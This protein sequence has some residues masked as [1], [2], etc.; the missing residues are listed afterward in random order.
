MAT[1]SAPAPAAQPPTP[2][3]APSLF[4][5]LVLNPVVLKELRGRMRGARAFIV[6]TVYLVLMSGF[7]LLLYNLYSAA[8]TTPYNA[9]SRGLVGKVVFFGVVGIELLLVSFIAPAFTVGALSGERERQTFDLLR[10]TLLSARS[11]V[12][13]KLGSSLSFVMLLLFAAVPLQ[14]MAFLLGG[15]AIEEVLVANLLL[16]VTAWMFCSAG[17]FFS[18]LMRRTLGATV[19]TYAFVLL[20]VLAL[21][22]LMVPV[23]LFGSFLSFGSGLTV[24]TQAFLLYAFWVLVMTNPLATVIAS[25]VVLVNYQSLWSFSLP[26][27][28]P[29][30]GATLLNAPLISPWLP[31]TLLATIVGALL[32]SAAIYNVSRRER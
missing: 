14:S 3:S 21:P 29:N 11:L 8:S 17:V 30:T 10:T 6:L 9:S 18:S 12:L 23:F 4:D 13:G 16:A 26:L 32:V 22:L 20:C 5:R 1:T 15:V 24:W 28:D 19:L 7:V 31:Y 27:T 25:E 2:A